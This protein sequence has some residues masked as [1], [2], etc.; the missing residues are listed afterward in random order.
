MHNVNIDSA[1]LFLYNILSLLFVEEYAKN[2]TATIV[3]KLNLLSANSFDDD[4]TEAVNKILDFL[5]NNSNDNFYKEYQRLFLIP[6]GDYV[7]LSA[8]WYYEEREAGAML[9]K[10]R[11]IM[12]KTKIRKDE[13]NFT[14][15]EDHYGFIF[16]LATYLIEQKIKGELEEDLQKELFSAVINPYCDQ[17]AFQLISSKANIYSH[18]GVILSNFCNFERTYLDVQRVKQP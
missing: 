11:D 10:V 14:A 5:Q 6:F 7:S 17:I 2:K 1:R 3:E 4:V 15:P 16:T 18:V 13:T 12:A 8:S 9:L